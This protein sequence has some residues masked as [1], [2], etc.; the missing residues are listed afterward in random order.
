MSMHQEAHMIK[1]STTALF[2]VMTL[3][4]LAACSASSGSAEPTAG[5]SAAPA[6]PAGGATA[7][8]IKDF[9]F[10]PASTSVPTGSKVTWTNSD[11]TAHTVTFDEG[12]ADSGN[13]APGATFDQTF[14]TAG[15]FAYHCT[16]HSQ[17]KGTV[18]VT[19]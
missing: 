10:N 9:A 14:A 17:M 8:A 6:A 19:P 5:T 3:I 16:I 1:R 7:V 12:S 4:A 18:T 2:V 13:L 15:T 11:T